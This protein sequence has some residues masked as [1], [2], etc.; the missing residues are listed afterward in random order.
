MN[1]NK[2][3]EVLLNHEIH[4][5]EKETHF[6]NYIGGQTFSQLDV[7]DADDQAHSA[8][9]AI[10]EKGIEEQIHRHEANL[11]EIQN[12]SFA[13]ADVVGPGAVVKV[14]DR[15]MVIVTALS[16][17]KFEDIEMIGMSTEAPIYSLIEGKKAGES[18]VM[19]G[20]TFKIQEVH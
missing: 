4:A 8:E 7:V 9:N 3:K 12:L 20:K 18:F 13:A 1:K 15:Y 5:I 14:N 11:A 10:I 2:L 17:F 19:N 16:K 6:E